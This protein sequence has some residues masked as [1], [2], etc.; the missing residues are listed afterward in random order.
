VARE[1]RD[2]QGRPW[3]VSLSVESAKRV[4]ASVQIVNEHG[5]QVPFDLIDTATINQTITVL[6]SQFIVVGDVLCAMLD[7]QLEDRGLTR[8]QFLDGLRGDAL[9]AGRKIVEDE[10]I[11]FFPNSLRK[12]IRLMAQ[13]MTEVHQVMMDRAEAQLE[14]VTVEALTEQFGAQ[15][16]KQP[17]S[18]ALTQADGHTANSALQEMPA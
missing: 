15:S 7:K 13:K 14:N 6:R 5:K 11:D 4:K 18:S 10:L 8:E 3:L 16:T 9:D 1:F 17:E 2:D 12:M